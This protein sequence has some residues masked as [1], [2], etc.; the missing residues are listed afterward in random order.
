MASTKISAMSAA[1]TPNYNAVIPVVQSADNFTLTKKQVQANQPNQ[2]AFTG[3]SL[4][5]DCA[6]NDV[7][8]VSG[9]D[10]RTWQFGFSNVQNG[11][12][13]HMIVSVPLIT[14]WAG[15]WLI[16]GTNA[17]WYSGGSGGGGSFPELTED[18]AWLLVFIGVGDQ[19]CLQ[20]YSRLASMPPNV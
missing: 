15:A 12:T 7:F 2:T 10:T 20:S 5:F 3:T 4:T 13:Y 6:V 19:A 1:T 16:P 17:N 18:A 11:K 8:R 14:S 9:Q